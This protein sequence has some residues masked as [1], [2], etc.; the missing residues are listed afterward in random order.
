MFMAQPWQGCDPMKAR[1]LFVGLDANYPKNVE[2]TLPE[3][4]DYLN[5]GVQ[6]WKDGDEGVHH[7]FLL[8]RFQGRSGKRYHKRFAEI[9][10]KP[11]HAELVSFVELL[12]LPTEAGELIVEDLSQEHLFF[13]RD[14]FDKGDAKYIFVCMG[15]TE[16]LRQADRKWRTAWFQW[17]RQLPQEV[18]GE[19]EVLRKQDGHTIYR[20]YH[21]SVRFPRHVE[22][23]NAQI[24]QIRQIVESTADAT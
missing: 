6:F 7:P 9:R 23:L 16:L 14:V 1:F 21:F 10:F 17:A 5:N 4:F 18:D 22:R 2:T 11:V 19:L 20:M 12:H 13:L 15:V 3:L 8:S 24:E